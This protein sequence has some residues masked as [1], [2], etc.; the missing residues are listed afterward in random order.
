MNNKLKIHLLVN[1]T[2]GNGHAKKIMDQV[3]L[4]LV[5]ENIHFDIKKSTYAGEL[6]KLAQVYGEHKHQKNEVLLII[7][8]DGSL[9]EALNGIKRSNNPQTPFAYLPAGTGNDFGRAAN[10]T[11]NP[12]KLL[13]HFKNGLTADRIDCGS[14]KLSPSSHQNYYFANSFGIGF[15]ACVN[16]FSNISEFKKILNRINEGKLIYSLN[17]LSSLRKQDTFSVEVVGD[18]KK[19]YYNKAFLVTT[20]NHPYLGGGISLLPSARIDSHKLDTVVIEKF[21]IRKLAK[22]FIKLL[23]DGSHVHD[24]QFHYIE[25]DKITV[26]T[27]KKEFAQLDGEEIQL[28]SFELEFAIDHFNLLR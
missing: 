14:F 10:L 11:S 4:L 12:K 28:S 27:N 7:G 20:T 19:R 22:L 8:G 5:N 6:I 21:T 16:H 15:D 18:G 2:A 25:A 24:T 9:N 1:E 26:K 17:I 23:K 13:K 3:V